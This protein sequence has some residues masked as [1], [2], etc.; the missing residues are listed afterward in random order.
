MANTYAVIMAGGSGTR[1][2]PF[3]R[4]NR[5]KQFL[6]VLGVGK[7]LLQMT[8]QR[9]QDITDTGNI[10]IVANQKYKDQI[11]EQL[12]EL[13]DSQ[14]LLE[15][16]QRNTAPCIAYACYKI[17]KKDPDARIVISPSDHIVLHNDVYTE[18]INKALRAAES[19][20]RLITI[21]VEPNRPETGYGYIQYVVDDLSE[22]K[23][24]KTFT[25]KPEKDLAQSFI[26]S[27]EFVWNAGIFVWSAKAIINAFEAH[28][29]EMAEVFSGLMESYYTKDEQRKVDDGYSQCR[30]ISID[31]GIMEKARNVFVILGDFGW[32]DLGSWQSLY[33]I[34]EKD[35]NNNVVHANAILY[36]SSGCT[37]KGPKEKLI[38]VSGIDDCLITD[39]GNAIL[40]CNKQRGTELKRIVHDIQ[41]T[42]GNKF[43]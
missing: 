30:N 10:L 2:W 19:D 24:V 28:L 27:G 29:P 12:P 9:F 39:F 1:F 3:S 38:V 16:F 31:F 7:S 11:L 43:T 6:D 33:E 40:I 41:T 4:S 8:F 25:E 15:P 14:L 37:I 26:E 42:K 22:V 35:V 36:D 20:E 17:A 13:D 21:G 32:S 23:R 34:S 18:I 5:P